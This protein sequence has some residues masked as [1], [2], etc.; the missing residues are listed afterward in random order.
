[1]CTGERGS[2]RGKRGAGVQAVPTEGKKTLSGPI[3]GKTGEGEVSRESCIVLGPRQ[4]D[5]WGGGEESKGKT[6]GRGGGQEG[7][8][9]YKRGKGAKNTGFGFPFICKNFFGRKGV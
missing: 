4:R 3:E 6:K 9:C 8:S 1:V 2:D 7:G 5:P